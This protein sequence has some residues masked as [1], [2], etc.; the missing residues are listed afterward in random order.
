MAERG[1][2]RLHFT[3]DQT[4]PERQVEAQS[5]GQAESRLRAAMFGA[6]LGGDGDRQRARECVGALPDRRSVNGKGAR[7]RRA[8]GGREARPRVADVL[9]PPVPSE[10]ASL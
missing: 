10:A 6:G 1:L 3:L 8:R 7:G 5:Q 2:L 4:P 9:L